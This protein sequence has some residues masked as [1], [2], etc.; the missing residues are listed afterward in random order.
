[1]DQELKKELDLK[2]N[3]L[4]DSEWALAC[5]KAVTKDVNSIAAL[6]EEHRKPFTEGRV[7]SIGSA[8]FASADNWREIAAASER[9]ARAEL[10]ASSPELAQLSELEAKALAAKQAADAKERELQALWS[11]F[12]ALPAKA[13]KLNDSLKS[14]ASELRGLDPQ[15]LASEFKAAYRDMQNGALGDP[16]ALVFA[17]ATIV[18]R[19]LRTEVLNGLTEK[20]QSELTDLKARSKVLATK[21]G[22][23]SP[24]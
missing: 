15:K 9:A 1:M 10:L 18:T 24:L 21:L 7:S 5:S 12:Q 20:L 2:F 16:F 6:I 23:K 4:G 3:C 14:I 8:A 22:M 13:Q 19:D 17:A 11:E